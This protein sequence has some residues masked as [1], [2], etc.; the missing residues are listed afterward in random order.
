MALPAV[1]GALRCIFN[2]FSLGKEACGMSATTGRT[3]ASASRRGVTL[4]EM[5]VVTAILG[6]LAGLLVPAA[7]RARTGAEG[8]KCRSNLAQI[9]K[10]MMLYT[11][12]WDGCYPATRW[13]DG[14]KQRWPFALRAFVGAPLTDNDALESMASNGNR[15]VNAV[16]LCPAV[17]AS[18]NQSKGQ[19]VFFREGS[20][21][22]NWGTFGPFYPNMPGDGISPWW[23][24]PVS[25][26]CI[27][28]PAATIVVADSFGNAGMEDCHAYT[29]DP[30]RPVH[31]H[32]RWGATGG[33]RMTPM[34]NR[35]S[36]RGNA[37]FADGH[38]APLTMREAGYNAEQPWEVD[39]TGDN[40]LWTGLGEA[41]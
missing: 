39:G 8:L 4:V 12:E 26:T 30:P 7:L 31:G 15:I 37:V 24:Y 16:F 5:L 19:R 22:Y 23:R 20:Y 21:G 27:E 25:H 1:P 6:L 2:P 32:I 10:A 41:N 38:A 18:K 35:H 28:K 33:T 40:S 3:G 13:A 29:L 11:M 34:D 36:G 14:T 9:G 17:R